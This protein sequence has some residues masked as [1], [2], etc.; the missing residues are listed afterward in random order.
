MP[1]PSAGRRAHPRLRAESNAG[2][3]AAMRRVTALCRDIHSI[4]GGGLVTDGR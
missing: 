2:L 1:L 3:A 4:G